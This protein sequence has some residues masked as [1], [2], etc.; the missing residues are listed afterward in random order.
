M[1]IFFNLQHQ[2]VVVT[3]E[4]CLMSSWNYTFGEGVKKEKKYDFGFWKGSPEKR[5][6]KVLIIDSRDNLPLYHATNCN[7]VGP[8]FTMLLI[9]IMAIML[10]SSNYSRMRIQKELS[11]GILDQYYGKLSIG[12]LDQ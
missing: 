6:Q 11:I 8:P 10:V 7:N 1:L 4:M 3:S 5:V 9:A 12:I 2:N